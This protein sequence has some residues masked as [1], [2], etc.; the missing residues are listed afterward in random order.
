M[1]RRPYFPQRPGYSTPELKPVIN[2]QLASQGSGTAI[3]D[4]DTDMNRL[5]V[6]GV[7]QIRCVD[8]NEVPVSA[9]VAGGQMTL[10]YTTPL[11]ANP[12]FECPR[13]E[14]AIGNWQGGRL[15]PGI[16]QF[17]TPYTDI[18]VALVDFNSTQVRVSIV[19]GNYNITVTGVPPVR[20]NTTNENASGC[21]FTAGLLVFDFSAG[22]NQ[23]G[24]TIELSSPSL[25]VRNST[26]GFLQ[27]FSF[28]LP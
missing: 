22:P 18:T 3:F 23:S 7:P 15:A 19:E 16:R 25:A 28:V 21:S 1:Q 17:A 10:V 5:V 13:G 14:E 2:W 4:L 20:N 12:T 6:K 27:S 8:T 26:G 11:P 24:D 9:T